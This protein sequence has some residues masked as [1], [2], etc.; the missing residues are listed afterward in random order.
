MTYDDAVPYIEY[1]TALALYISNCV[2]SVAVSID[3]Y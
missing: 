3:I 2:S 1:L